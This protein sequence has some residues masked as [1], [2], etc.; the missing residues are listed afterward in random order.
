M[1]SSLWPQHCSLPGSSFHGISQARI[2]EWV[3]IS[4][5]GGSSW[6]TGWTHV[7]YTGRWIIYHRPTREASS[8]PGTLMCVLV[9]LMESLSKYLRC[10][11]LWFC[12]CC[13]STPFFFLLHRLDDFIWAILKVAEF[14]CLL[15]KNLLLN[16]SNEFLISIT[17]LFNSKIS[18][19]VFFI[20]FISLPM[21]SIWWDF[22]L[23]V[24]LHSLSLVPFEHT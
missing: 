24:S 6:P 1:S 2:L 7:S 16:L 15:K 3:V 23:L 12:S 22:F 18:I 8:L 4:F 10:F 19:Q 21:V 11:K 5:S 20:I 9:E 13:Y 14:F 17:V